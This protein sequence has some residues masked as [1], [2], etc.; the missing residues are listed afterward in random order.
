MSDAIARKKALT[1]LHAEIERYY[2]MSAEDR[3]DWAAVSLGEALRLFSL[4]CG[5][6]LVT[7]AYGEPQAQERSAALNT[8][9]DRLGLCSLL[10]ADLEQL[11][12]GHALSD[13]SAEAYLVSRGDKPHL[14]A[15]IPSVQGK[16]NTTYKIALAELRALQWDAWLAETGEKP[17]ARHEA[18]SAAF[19]YPWDS[20]RKWGST[21]P[22]KLGERLYD[23]HIQVAKR[24]AASGSPLG[25]LARDGARY[26][27]IRGFGR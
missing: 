1:Q 26:R 25:D 6:E 27:S 14:F 10:F 11:G 23:Y 18:I 16:R 12:S 17:E 15:P 4:S 8:L 21:L 22:S 20:I 9:S 5:P 13:A 3:R 7:L 19:G 2:R 24:L